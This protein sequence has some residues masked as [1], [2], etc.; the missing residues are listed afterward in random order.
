MRRLLLSVGLAVGLVLPAGAQTLRVAGPPARL[1]LD[2]PFARPLYAPDGSRLAFTRPDL[3]GLFVAPAEGGA[4]RRLTDAPAAGFGFAWSPDGQHLAARPA[5]FDGPRRAD[6]LVLYD[7]ADGS[8]RLLLDFRLAPVAL[9]VWAAGGAE[10]WLPGRTVERFA[11]GL[12]AAAGKAADAPALV[13]DGVALARVAAD[14]RLEPLPLPVEGAVLNPALSPGGDRVAFEVLGGGL[15][16]MQVDGSGLR[17]LGD[18]HRPRW[19]PDGRWLVVQRTEDDGHRFTASDLYAVRA[20][21][22]AAVRL[23]DT[24]DRL[25]MNPAWRPDGRAIAFDTLDEGALYV[26]PVVI[27]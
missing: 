16:V 26:L 7:A 6:A 27:E 3:S 19:S 23:T 20:D 13:L 17:A 2:G 4:V 24:R 5:R 25:E 22:G 21:G 14:G 12:P 15:Y 10:V 8:A 9:P 18:G 1:L 11:T